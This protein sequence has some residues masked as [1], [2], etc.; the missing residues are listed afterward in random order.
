MI[1]RKTAADWTPEHVRRLWTY[2]NSA[3]HLVGENFSYQVGPGIVNFLQSTGR[4]RGK[5]LDYGSGLGYLL[6]NLLARGLECSAA[7]FSPEAVELVNRKFAA[8]PNWRG[9]VLV[10]G[11]PTPFPPASFDVITCTETLEHL[12][13][14]LL[15]GVV[16]EMH[17]LVRPG[18]VVLFTT[19]H[20]EDLE[21]SM[22]YCPFCEAEYHK[23]QH[24][25]SFTPESMSR[26]LESHGFRVLFCRNINFR[27]FQHHAGRPP[28]G[29]MSLKT[30]GAW[31]GGKRDRFLDRMSPRPFPGGR[32]FG[33]RAVPG[34]HLCA[35]VTRAE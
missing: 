35:V 23:V 29:E 34:P 12:S 32:D 21:Q 16:G 17:R 24:Q 2:W 14:E 25:R 18:G 15:A 27:E 3:P 1:E 4:L 19:P 33:R 13:D 7:E 5:V 26:L 31:L 9:A 30:L 10:S 20:A 8:D 22:T 6:Q 28:L 11:L